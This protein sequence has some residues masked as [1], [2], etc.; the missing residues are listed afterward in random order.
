MSLYLDQALNVA[1]RAVQA[2]VVPRTDQ[3]G[4]GSMRRFEWSV[5]GNCM[6]P[7]K[8]EIHGRPSLDDSRHKEEKPVWVELWARC[9][10]CAACAR[11]K[12]GSWAGRGSNEVDHYQRTWFVTLTVRA[13]ARA[14]MTAQ[15]IARFN[16]RGKAQG[17]KRRVRVPMNP[18]LPGRF[19]YVPMSEVKSWEELP[20]DERFRLVAA[21]LSKEITKMFKRL[22]K[23][24]FELRY[25]LTA[26]FHEDG[27]PH[28]HLLLHEV[29][30]TNPITWRTIQGAWPF[31]FV[32]AKLIR[33]T[34]SLKAA[35]YVCKYVAKDA[36][37][38]VR[39]SVGYG[40][41]PGVPWWA[42][43]TPSGIAEAMA[44]QE[45]DEGV[46]PGGEPEIA[47]SNEVNEMNDFSRL[48]DC[49]R[50]HPPEW[51]EV[52]NAPSKA[53]KWLSKIFG[54]EREGYETDTSK[55][56]F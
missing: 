55:R 17:E 30:A 16:D 26:E 27:F 32:K 33:K 39:A 52:S 29:D 41:P 2:G 54:L 14:Q 3:D 40:S 46:G 13:Q 18:E 10:K 24:G 37:A 11:N 50:E 20:R 5:S 25:L 21:E 36:V 4:R 42:T 19:T 7:V 44:P 22:R 35:W 12:A 34:S 9:R 48:R 49:S 43:L 6:A 47:L 38:R 15:A 31:G 1:R 53:T 23:Q 8:R 45:L 51:G 28:W 56:R